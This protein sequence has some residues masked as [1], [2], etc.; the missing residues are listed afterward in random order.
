MFSSNRPTWGKGKPAKGQQDVYVSYSW[1]LTD[2]TA[3]RNWGTRSTRPVWSNGRRSPQTD[4]VSI[5][6]RDGDIY[7][8][9]RSGKH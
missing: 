2:W 3:P 5:S 6:G 7:V 8:S 1:W 9:S 4:G